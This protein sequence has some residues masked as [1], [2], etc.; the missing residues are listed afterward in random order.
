MII[1][2]IS[3]F[4]YPSMDGSWLSIVCSCH[5]DAISPDWS[6]DGPAT[7]EDLWFHVNERPG[8]DAS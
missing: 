1:F 2:K 4:D 8:H 7:V 3:M 5:L 6:L